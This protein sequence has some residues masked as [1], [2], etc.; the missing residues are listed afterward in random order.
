MGSRRIPPLLRESI[1]ELVDQVCWAAQLHVGSKDACGGGGSTLLCDNVSLRGGGGDRGVC[2]HDVAR[3]QF[4]GGL[5]AIVPP[6]L[7]ELVVKYV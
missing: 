6:A 1:A 5:R 4:A 7:A 3:E 2:N